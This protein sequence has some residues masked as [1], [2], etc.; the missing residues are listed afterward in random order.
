MLALVLQHLYDGSGNLFFSYGV[1]D[2]CSCSIDGWNISKK[3]CVDNGTEVAT[4]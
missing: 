4:S 3:T 1:H 2:P